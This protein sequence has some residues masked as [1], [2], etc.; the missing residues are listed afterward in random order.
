LAYQLG[1]FLSCLDS[2]NPGPACL[3]AELWLHVFEAL[4]STRDLY[5]HQHSWFQPRYDVL[6]DLCQEARRMHVA[7]ALVCREWHELI[8]PRLF[9]E[10]VLGT[11]YVNSYPQHVAG[12]CANLTCYHPIAHARRV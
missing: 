1:L 12:V 2:M 9:R 8:R 10:V 6:I 4:D 5:S 7:I 11:N 3:P